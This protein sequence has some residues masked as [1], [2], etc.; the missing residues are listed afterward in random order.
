[1]K[2]IK[3]ILLLLLTIYF[4]P[5]AAQQKV[6]I[7]TER[8]IM[9]SMNKNADSL[10]KNSE[11]Y[12]VSIGIVKDGRTY[13]KHY[14]Q[15]DKGKGN[16][17]NN[18]TFFEIASVTKV[19]TG[20]LMAQAVLERKVHLDDDIRKYIN[21]SYTNL[22][23]KG[24]PIRIKDVI[25]FKTG[26]D[27]DLPDNRELRTK[28]KDSLNF[29]SKELDEAYSKQK[30]FEDLKKVK[31]DTI[32]GT[33][34]KYSNLS[35][36]LSA[37]ILEN[38]YHK[39]YEQLL[40]ENI[41]SKLGMQSTRLNLSNNE[42]IANG[43]NEH[44]L[45]MP[46]LSNN[47]WGSDGFLK[48]TLSDMTK[49]LAYE[50]DTTN[51]I[52]RESQRNVT[53]SNEEW[54]GYFWDGIEVA[55][56]GKICH[57]QGGSFGTQTM[58]VVFPERKL[59]ICIVVNINAPNTYDCL[60]KAIS[61]IAEDLKPQ[62]KTKSIYGYKITG[63]KV[64]FTYTHAKPL[65]ANLIKSITV[66]GSFNNWSLND[67]AYEMI[68]K[69]NHVFELSLPKSQF[70][71]GKIYT[72]KFLINNAASITTPKNASNVESSADKTLVLKIN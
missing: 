41:T 13:T 8:D 69:P 23:Y 62:N 51:K 46:H 58:F 42:K 34:Y 40:K 31:V 67:K 15:I 64:I 44:H 27:R 53:Q 72:F 65:N 39:T 20:L 54:Y 33:T 14:G 43:Y 9:S 49:F 25:S 7:L 17:A 24:Y 28:N 21:G 48:S 18:S 6:D 1:M 60:L 66:A 2:S 59:G 11:A 29:Y 10:L 52:V 71:K 61:G 4:F 26:L 36:E 35:L 30:F 38:V 47:L 32:P 70:E 5:S 63:D 45:L 55:D 37:H 68:S 22:E 56:N 57:K 16:T 19:F 3:L 50:L 12:S